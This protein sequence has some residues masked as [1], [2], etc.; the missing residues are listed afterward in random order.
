MTPH[1]KAS[2]AVNA[3]LER[4]QANLRDATGPSAEQFLAQSLVVTIGMAEALN[5][6]GAAVGRQARRRHG[7]I[8]RSN[9]RLT[10]QHGELLKTGRELLE[11]LKANPADRAVRKEIERLQGE[12]AGLQKAVRHGAYTLQRE[13]APGLAAV[14]PM[15]VNL[16]RLCEADAGD[17]LKRVVKLVAAEVAELYS[18]QAEPATRRVFAAQAWES[19]ALADI[20]GAVEFQDAYARAGYQ[21]MVALELMALTASESPPAAAEEAL[22]RGGEAAAARLKGITARLSAQG[23]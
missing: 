17:A 3:S 13:L 1:E 18:R 23:A 21:M 14:D 20:D 9:E 10:A 5:D 4:L 15:A 7:E 11:R 19:A 22:Q 8:K 12:M 2:A 16:R 6:Y